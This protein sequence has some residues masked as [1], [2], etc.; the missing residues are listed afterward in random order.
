MSLAEDQHPVG[1]LHPGG[2]HMN[3]IHLDAYTAVLAIVV[4][5][6]IVVIA[7]IVALILALANPVR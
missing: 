7:G 4:I 6:V 1:D 2:A 3:R 5:V